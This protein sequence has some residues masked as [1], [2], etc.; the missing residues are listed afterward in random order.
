VQP[1]RQRDG[2]QAGKEKGREE[3]HRRRCLNRK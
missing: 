2:A 1:H 3:V